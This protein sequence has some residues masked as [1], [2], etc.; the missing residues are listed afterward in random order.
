MSYLNLLKLN[1]K[2]SEISHLLIVDFIF[3]PLSDE[4]Q[5][6]HVQKVV[7]CNEQKREVTVLHSLNNK[8]I[9]KVFT[10][11]KVYS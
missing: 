8:P 10:F 3:R 5:K 2:S 6:S 1:T 11:D 4:E 7:S 9:D